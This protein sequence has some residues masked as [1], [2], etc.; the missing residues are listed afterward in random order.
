MVQMGM[1]QQDCVNGC[2]G[3]RKRLPVPQAQPFVALEQPAVDQDS[4]SVEVHQVAGAGNGV[5]GAKKAERSGVFTGH[6]DAPSLG[7]GMAS[8]GEPGPGR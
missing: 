3:D 8:S 1:R 2:R 5:R 7:E 4:C 6:G